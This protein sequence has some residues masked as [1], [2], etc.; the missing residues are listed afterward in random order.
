[1]ITPDKV[2]GIAIKST[3]H[4]DADFV[5]LF[6]KEVRENGDLL[7]IKGRKNPFDSVEYI[8]TKQNT[9]MFDFFNGSPRIEVVTNLN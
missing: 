5:E 8:K 9:Y 7:S 4:A 1:M 2:D 3:N 6:H